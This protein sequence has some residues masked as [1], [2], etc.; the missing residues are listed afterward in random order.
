MII[1]SSENALELDRGGAG[2]HGPDGLLQER[3]IQLRGTGEPG[4]ARAPPLQRRRP[5][6]GVDPDVVFVLGP[7]GKPAVELLQPGRHPA[8]GGGPAVGG[9]LDQE[10]A[11]DRFEETFDLTASLG[12]TGQSWLILWITSGRG[13]RVTAWVCGGRVQDG[14]W[15]PRGGGLWRRRLRGCGA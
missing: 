14:G 2:G 11:P 15:F 10:L 12:L 4:R 9:N 8:A 6:R 1:S 3:G 5:G 7:G 13:S